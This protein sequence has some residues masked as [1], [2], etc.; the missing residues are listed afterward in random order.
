MPYTDYELFTNMIMKAGIPYDFYA[1]GWARVVS[2][3]NVD[4]TF[5]EDGN[6]ESIHSD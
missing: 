6:L 3:E 1:E 5:D 2:I 4:I